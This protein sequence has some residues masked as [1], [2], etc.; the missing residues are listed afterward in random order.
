MRT[1]VL[2][3]ID[4]SSAKLAAT[5]GTPGA[6]PHITQRKCSLARDKPKAC[7]QAHVW[8]T[9]LIEEQGDDADVY[10]FLELPVMG[11]G[12]PGSTIPQARINGAVTAGA[13]IAGATVVDVN[14][15]HCKK[16]VVG[17]GN[18]TKEDIA[19]WCREAWPHAY[20]MC[21]R[22]QD[23]IDSVMIWVYGKK[24]I[25]MRHRLAKKRRRAQQPIR[26]RM[27]KTA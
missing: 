7:A 12:G 11:R 13:Q 24:V 4:P 26:R 18:A 19:D 2:I 3:G 27:E 10:V 14:N 16:D 20:K 9:E 17:R 8:I 6:E 21:E 25:A 23:L 1:L 15:A 5:I 22:D